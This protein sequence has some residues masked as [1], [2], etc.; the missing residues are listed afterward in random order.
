MGVRTTFYLF[1][2]ASICSAV[3]SGCRWIDPDESTPA[4]VRIDEF[5]FVGDPDYGSSSEKITEVW[6]FANGETIGAIPLDDDSLTIPVMPVLREGP[7]EFAFYAGVK[8]N[9][10][11]STRILYPFYNAY[12]ETLDLVPGETITVA[13]EFSY[14]DNA[15]VAHI[16][17]FE[18]AGFSYDGAGGTTQVD[19]EQTSVDQE[20]FEGNKSGRVII[21]EDFTYF[22]HNTIDVFDLPSGKQIFVELD[23]KCNNSFAIGVFA[24]NGSGRDKN[25]VMVVNPTTD[26]NGVDQWNKLYVELTD[27]AAANISAAFFELYFESNRD[28]ENTEARLFF[29]NIK[30]IHF[31]G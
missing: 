6:V 11:S 19:M 21:S 30:I 20:V 23:Y 15:I 14:R 9:G 18:S 25:L 31:P 4:F 5:T 12:V 10:V 2:L 22:E 27:V 7:V 26:E 1:F 3:L 17:D 28:A 16:E 13:P 29:D 8:N 24:A